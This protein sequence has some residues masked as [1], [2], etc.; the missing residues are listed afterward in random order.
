MEPSLIVLFLASEDPPTDTL[1][2]DARLAALLAAAREAWPQLSVSD[3]QLVRYAGARAGAE[4]TALQRVEQLFWSD[5]LL[6]CGC[7]GG[8]PAALASFETAYLG[9]LPRIASTLKLGAADLDDLRQNVRERLLTPTT[10]GPPRIATYSGRGSLWGW[11][12]IS[13]LR[14]GLALVRKAPPA[15]VP[16]TELEQILP[17]GGLDPELQAMKTRYRGEFKASFEQAF[18][19][20]TVEERNVL[21]QYFVDRLTFEELGTAYQVNRSTVLRRLEKAQDHLVAQL[22]VHLGAVLRVS[23][24]ELDSILALI[25]TDVGASLL[26]QLGARPTKS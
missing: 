2:A 17:D 22:R 20:L 19:D 7:A 23:S 21:R 26:G 9:Q 4:G 18:A 16:L 15:A 8:D 10:S 1:E 24:G 3:E 14:E 11:F 5:L 25:R 13:A 6:A 12:R